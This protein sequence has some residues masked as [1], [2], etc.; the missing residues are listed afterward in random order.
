MEGKKQSIP[1][2][3]AISAQAD[4]DDVKPV[5]GG[6][7]NFMDFRERDLYYVDK[8]ALIDRV[9]SDER[10]S[11]FLFTRPRRF[12]KSLNLSMLDAYL[13]VAYR[14]S[15]NNWFE[16]L[17]V[18][19]LRPDDPDRNSVPVIKINLK[20]LNVRSYERFL[21]SMGRKIAWAARPFKYIRPSLDDDDKDVFE[22]IVR[23]RCDESLLEES[24][25]LL[26]GMVEAYHGK[27]VVILIDEYDDATNNSFGTPSH[28]EILGFMKRFYGNALKSNDSLRFAVVTGIMQVT[29][30]GIFSGLNNV[31]VDN[32]LSTGFEEMFGFTSDEIRR[33]CEDA[34]HP[35]KFDEIREW[36]DGYRFGDADIYN[37]WSV[38]SYFN[39]NMVPDEYWAGTSGN[40]IIDD[41]LART[42]VETFM[43]LTG[44]GEGRT[45]TS[46]LDNRVA[47]AGRSNTPEEL[48]SIMVASGY[49]KAVPTDDGKYALSVPNLEMR[50]VFLKH[51]LDV[52]GP[53]VRNLAHDVA[54]ALI[55]GDTK[56]AENSLREFM[57][58]FSFK[59]LA[60]EHT[61]QTMLLTIFI[62]VC[63]THRPVDE[64]MCG[65][66]YCDLVLEGFKEGSRDILIEYKALDGDADRDE[67]E[68]TARR[69]LEQIRRKDYAHG[70]PGAMAYGIAFSGKRAAVILGRRRP[71]FMPGATRAESS[72]P[73]LLAALGAPA[74]V[75]RDA[76][77]AVGAGHS[78]G[79]LVDG[80]VHVGDLHHVLLVEPGAAP[81]AGVRVRG[82]LG[83]ALGAGDVVLLLGPHL[84]RDVDVRSA[85]PADDL[86]GEHHGAALLAAP[87]SLG[88]QPSLGLHPVAGLGGAPPH[89]GGEPEDDEEQ[90]GDLRHG[91]EGAH[92]RQRVDAAGRDAGVVGE[93]MGL[94]GGLDA[95]VG[96]TV[97]GDLHVLVHARAHVVQCDG[98]RVPSLGHRRGHLRRQRLYRRIA[99]SRRRLPERYPRHVG[100][101]DADVPVPEVALAVGLD[102]GGG[103]VHAESQV[104]GGFGLAVRDLDAVHAAAV[105]GAVDVAEL[106]PVGERPHE[107]RQDDESH[108]DERLHLG[109]RDP[110]H[111]GDHVQHDRDDEEPEAGCRQ[112]QHREDERDGDR[113]DDRDDLLG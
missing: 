104:V 41:L 23:S 45:I 76:L 78:F 58:S 22:T 109:G 33:L 74:G 42:S 10:R 77:A 93:R 26:S 85:L 27:K 57:M 88:V 69:A 112:P 9:L 37:P 81:G 60:K 68:K 98:E 4:T 83:A 86:P 61:Y 105:D 16:G 17:E 75:G 101:P 35:E 92:E 14:D 50:R 7:D 24:V 54:G 111:V 62:A 38:L 95:V 21:N 107:Q 29:K 80:A 59:T 99:R 91:D 97:E 20:E 39:R 11:V 72:L 84:L 19:R 1:K 32:V 94:E 15:P 6:I 40:G 55:R 63:G 44:L 51:I 82:D 2:G 13:N 36:Y 71:V 48:Y 28:D 3:K 49:L 47:Y 108:P 110:Q 64:A 87:V 106:R 66:G 79:G 113:R 43:D 30:E 25:K 70:R 34:E 102:A 103:G 12:G 65:D 53:G 5:P 18:E 56:L 52:T 100:V 89:H 73:D 46:A 67:M 96:D 8:S 31:Y 90:Q